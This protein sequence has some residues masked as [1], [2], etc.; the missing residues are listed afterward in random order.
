[1]ESPVIHQ[2]DI[3]KDSFVGIASRIYYEF[4]Y[5]NGVAKSEMLRAMIHILLLKAERIKDE[6]SLGGVKIYWIETFNAFRNL[7]Q[8]EYIN[9]RS[10]RV[11]ADKLLISYSLLNDVVKKLTN[12]TVKTFIDNYVI[13]EIKRYL[14]STS[15]SVN[16]I[17]YKT[18][19]EES[20]HMINFFKKNT[21]T[22]PLKF[23]QQP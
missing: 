3:G 17:S 20:A 19:F 10:S 9:T 22:T 8:K 18:G 21:G 1:M 11:Y 12:N 2:K 23:R 7:L 14:V 16:E 15:L 6:Q 13:L 4:H 5:P